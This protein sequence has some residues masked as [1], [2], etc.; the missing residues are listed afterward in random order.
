MSESLL[1][2]IDSPRNL[3]GLSGQDLERLASEIRALIT[4]TVAARGGHLA[5]NLGVVDLTLALHRTYDFARDHLVWDVGHQ[6]YAH[7]ILTGRRE[8]F[9]GL[10][11]ASGA[12]GFPNPAE[13]PYDAFRTGH[14]GASVSTALGLA[15]AE[16]AAGTG[17][18]T[19]AVIGDGALASG[20][21]LEAM[22]HA[23]DAAADLLVVLNDNEMA[24]SPTVG[25]LARHL[26]RLRATPAYGNL[27]RDVHDVLDHVPMGDLLSR[28]IHT[29]KDVLKEAVVPEHMFER[30]G[31]RCYGPVD[32]HDIADL[33]E[34]LE[35]LQGLPGPV[36]LHVVTQKGRGFQP[37]AEK[38]EAW[39]SAS[40][41]T[42]RNGQVM[43]DREPAGPETWTRAAVDALLALAEA[44]ER[45]VA[46]TAAMPEGSG[47]V[48]FAHRYPDRFF[49]V[50]I[51]EQHAVGL[52]AGLARGGRRPVVGIYSTFLQ[53]AYDQLF[54]EI[55]IQ[56]LPVVFLVDRAGLVGADGPTHHGLYDVAYLRHLPG[57]TVAAPADRGELAGMLRLATEAEGPWAVRYPRDRVPA[58]ALADEA[59]R[60][61]RGAVVRE[62]A[63]GA[64]L[65]L[66]ATVGS[67]VEA[68]GR[69]AE[70]GVEVAVASARF[71]R[72]LDTDLLANLLAEQPWVLT[73]EDA[74]AAGGFG[75]A[76]LEA[77]EA[78]GLDASKIRRAAVEDEIVEHDTRAAQLAG[79]GLDADGLTERM[80]ALMEKA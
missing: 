45:L 51:C 67:A 47:L 28:S 22:N 15:L 38:P 42:E 17:V 79:Q 44:D 55:A 4:R 27:K 54:H 14:A 71:V 80:R 73:V 63:G 5:S 32:G 20:I 16:Q 35:E 66:G 70:D 8:A 57:F 62:G 34:V 18:R 61:G 12:S 37:A 9:E 26:T 49:D 64:V 11:T 7:K 68:A 78:M 69:L 30:L 3:R 2:Q 36:L 1:D 77:A 24:I 75:A 60:P 10:R 31:F 33:L 46:I 13:S 72:P 52:A 41:F 43:T 65:A 40:P 6:C 21:A 19:V 23:G 48:R 29:F 58:A 74:A 53:R 25:A 50:G 76:V 56:H 59:V 39:H